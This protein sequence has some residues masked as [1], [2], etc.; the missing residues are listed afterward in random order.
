MAAVAAFLVLTIVVLWIR[1]YCVRDSMTLR[2]TFRL[3]DG[4]YRDRSLNA[5]SIG[6]GLHLSVASYPPTT[7]PTAKSTFQFEREPHWEDG[8][9]ASFWS[10]AVGWVVPEGEVRGYSYRIPYRWLSACALAGFVIADIRLDRCY[11]KRLYG[12]CR[13]CG[14]NLTGNVSGVCPECGRGVGG[15]A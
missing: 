3:R 13:K 11:R 14:Y 10:G 4:R 6:G 2:H 9:D 8:D 1:S 12:R 15:A 7:R 5:L